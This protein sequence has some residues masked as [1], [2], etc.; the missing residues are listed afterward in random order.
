MIVSFC[1]VLFIYL[2]FGCRGSS[3]LY[4]AVHRLLCAAEQG[5]LSDVVHG[6]LTEV[7][8]LVAEHG[9]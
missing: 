9:F 1:F 8:S 2:F 6:L 4:I 7:A 5:L 3:L